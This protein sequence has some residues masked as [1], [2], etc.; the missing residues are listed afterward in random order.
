MARMAKGNRLLP[1]ADYQRIY[2]VVYSVLQE[3]GGL[4]AHRACLFFAGAGMMILREHYKL[5]ASLSA[6]GVALMVVDE[7][8]SQ[9]IVYGRDREGL[10]V[11]EKDAFHAWVQCDGWL[12]DFMAPILGTAIRKDGHNWKVPRYMLQK[13]LSEGKEA[14][15]DI[16]QAG[17]FC[18]SPNPDLTRHVIERIGKLEE[19]LLTMCLAWYRRPPKPLPPLGMADH[20]GSTRKL[21]LKAPSVDGAW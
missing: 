7:P 20:R 3:S 10:F 2:Q 15:G 9:V 13:P 16:Q 8:K 1:L 5:D 19:K 18:L 11:G 17:D 4:S 12:L 21:V 14:V 6:G